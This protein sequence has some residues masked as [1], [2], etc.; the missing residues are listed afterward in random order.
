MLANWIRQT[1]TTPGAGD[2][3]LSAVANHCTFADEFVIGQP[4]YY[5]IQRDSDGSAVE[6]GIGKLSASNTLVRLAV[7]QTFDGS[8]NNAPSGH[9]S[10]TA[11]TYRVIC[12]GTMQQGG[13]TT[14][15]GITSAAALRAAVLYPY[16]ASANNRTITANQPLVFA[17]RIDACGKGI[18]ALGVAITTAAGNASNKLRIGVY[19]I[20]TDGSPGA[21]VAET[22]DI[23]VDTTGN[24][25]A[26]LAGGKKIIPP[27][28]YYFAILSDVA[29]GMSSGST[30]VIAQTTPLGMT[31]GTSPASFGTCASVSAGWSSMPSSITI[32]SVSGIGS[33][34]GPLIYCYP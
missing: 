6:H 2:L 15:P 28:W 12:A 8:F 33:G 4:F 23:Q 32:S 26:S 17:G 27:G 13:V 18:S 5:M 24:K 16:V 29:P 21:L 22:N 34:F 25:S 9:V 31:S 3:T 30:S 20:N 7:L 19:A 1:T 10:L 14:F 11:G